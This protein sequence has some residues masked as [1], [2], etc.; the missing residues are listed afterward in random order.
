MVGKVIQAALIL[1]SRDLFSIISH[2]DARKFS[3][4]LASTGGAGSVDSIF[5]S[6]LVAVLLA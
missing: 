5:I 1:R 3:T 2:K 6:G 4:L